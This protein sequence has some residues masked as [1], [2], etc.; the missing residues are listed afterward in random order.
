MGK[1]GGEKVKERRGEGVETGIRAHAKIL[2]WRPLC[3]VV[4]F[5][6]FFNFYHPHSEG[7][8]VF[9]S[10]CL[11]SCLSVSTITLKPLEMSSRNFQGIMIWLKGRRNSKMA[12]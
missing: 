10:V 12:I 1:R 4:L 11:F 5:Q 3:L 2:E 7:A 9:S 6:F 8:I